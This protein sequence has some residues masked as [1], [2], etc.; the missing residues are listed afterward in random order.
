MVCSPPCG[1]AIEFTCPGCDWWYREPNNRDASKMGVRPEWI[2]QALK[3]YFF[4]PATWEE[5]GEEEL[6]V[7]FAQ[8]YISLEVGDTNE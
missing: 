3:E 6:F 4:Q 7:A 5:D 2:A 1:G 8:E